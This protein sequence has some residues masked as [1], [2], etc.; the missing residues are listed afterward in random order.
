MTGSQAMNM[1]KELQSVFQGLGLNSESFYKTSAFSPL[2]VLLAVII[3]I[4]LLI[5]IFLVLINI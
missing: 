4:I 5:I 3:V 2:R 1:R